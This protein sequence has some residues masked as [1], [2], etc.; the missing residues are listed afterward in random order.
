MSVDI[1]V[2]IPCVEDRG[3]LDEAILSAKNQTFTGT[4][5]IILASDGNASLKS[6]A[7]NHG[8]LFSLADKKN[9]S[10]NFNTAVRNANGEFIKV[11]A[12][13]DLLTPNSLEDL[14]KA[15]GDSSLVYA[16]SI[17]FLGDSTSVFKSQ[18]PINGKEYYLS[19]RNRI[20]GG[21]IMYRKDDF[22]ELGGYDENINCAEEYDY[23]LNLLAHG[24][25]FV[26]T[27]S[28]V[29]KYRKH[30]GQ[31]HKKNRQGRIKDLHY[32]R[33][34]YRKYFINETTDGRSIHIQA[35]KG[36]QPRPKVLVEKSRKHA[37]RKSI[38]GRR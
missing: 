33:S 36:R 27:D 14:Y 34:K 30:G 11:L 19:G 25:T 10:K 13:D 5:E 28:E 20:H 29:Y 37:T 18:H 9:L 32:I 8:I 7:E 35:R 1:S 16:N 21:T 23:Y 4:Y 24:K 17:N 22:L 31:K 2:I 15:I 12:D 26:Y 3:Y 6:I 38:R